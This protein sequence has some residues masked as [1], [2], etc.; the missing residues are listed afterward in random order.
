MPSACGAAFVALV[1]VVG[2]T[3]LALTQAPPPAPKAPAAPSPESVQKAGQALADVHKALGGDKL[4]AI[5][6]IV[7]SGQTR[8]IR[9]N[10]LVPIEFEISIEL[11]DK[12]VRVD[13]VPGGGYRSDIGRIQR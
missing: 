12:Y 3:T 5:K 2:A 1:A 4:A 9:G 8:R 7:A 13:E 11:P 10:N 6:T